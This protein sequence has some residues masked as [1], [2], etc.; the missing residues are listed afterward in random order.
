MTS[1]EPESRDILRKA[2][3]DSSYSNKY[4][5]I[6]THIRFKW[7]LYN[8]TKAQ[9]DALEAVIGV[10]IDLY[11]HSDYPS[12]L[13]AIVK[14]VQP[15]MER[16]FG[17]LY[18][19]DIECLSVNYFRYGDLIAGYVL[20][21]GVNDYVSAPVTFGDEYSI[22]WDYNGNGVA[23]PANDYI[24]QSVG[25][26][27]I[28]T[29]YSDSSNKL[30][31]GVNVDVVSSNFNLPTVAGWH[32]VVATCKHSTQAVTMY[33]D[34]VVSASYTGTI[35]TTPPDAT[36]LKIFDSTNTDSRFYRNIIKTSDIMTLTDA[37]NH[38]NGLYF[39]IDNKDVFYACND[40]SGDLKDISGNG[41]DATPQNVSASFYNQTLT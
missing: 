5:G 26:S 32:S 4:I 15:K 13:K 7:R 18:Y 2:V 16:N 1:K 27:E 36:S 10:V 9:I 21:D 30:K 22:A 12:G 14:T 29:I 37:Q 24:F 35:G 6:G 40:A 38:Y 34:G 33:L 31:L 8:L 39:N 28:L 20:P 11:P 25:G 23:R 3:K 19:T 41:S 17:F